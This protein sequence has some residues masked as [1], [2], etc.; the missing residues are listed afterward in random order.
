MGTHFLLRGKQSLPSKNAGTFDYCRYFLL[1]SY[2]KISVFFTL[3]FCALTATHAG[4]FLSDEIELTKSAQDGFEKYKGY[5]N[6]K[7]FAVSADGGWGM[8]TGK[9]ND[10]QAIRKALSL[11]QQHTKGNCKVYDLDDEA[12]HNKYLQFLK[13][14]EFAV[15]NMKVQDTS[16][17]HEN[18]DW[19]LPQVRQLRPGREGFHYATPTSIEDVKNISTVELADKV[20]KKQ[21]SVIDALGVDNSSGTLPF[22]ISL[23]G[24]ANLADESEQTFNKNLEE[25]LRIVMQKNFPKKD[26][27]IAVFCASEE[28]WISVNVLLRLK[29]LGYTNLYWYRGGL[30]AW[31]SAKLPLVKPVPLLTVMR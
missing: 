28:C 7:A 3:Y 19:F 11:C 31:V 12:Y 9:D 6:K 25:D 10:V 21:I 2:M 27:P 18:D 23:D 4:N 20:A 8:A 26:A 15:K 16:Q 22:A 30:S 17:V 1:S 5:K 14:S 13:D 29:D 24:A